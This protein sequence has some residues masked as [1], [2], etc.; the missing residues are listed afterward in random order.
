MFNKQ[1]TEDIQ[2]SKQE[3]IEYRTLPSQIDYRLPY[4]IKADK[5]EKYIRTLNTDLQKAIFNEIDAEV[6]AYYSEHGA[7]Q[8]DELF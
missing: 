3:I 6:N 4:K 8:Y 1:R 7:A 5:A 2:K